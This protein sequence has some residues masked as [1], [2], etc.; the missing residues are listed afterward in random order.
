ME[1]K[2]L[3]IAELEG[4]ELQ[5]T[6]KNLLAF[7]GLKASLNGELVSDY[8]LSIKLNPA[9][10]R[11]VCATFLG[12]PWELSQLDAKDVEI[13]QQMHELLSI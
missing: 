3:I 7:E 8:F 12:L 4:K 11:S 6:F 9:K 10:W 13:L 2:K 1:L 5:E